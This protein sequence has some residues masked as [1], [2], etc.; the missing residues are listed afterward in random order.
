MKLGLK[1]NIGILVALCAS[2]TLGFNYNY[3]LQDQNHAPEI[4]D[5]SAAVSA[6]R[7][8]RDQLVLPLRSYSM[9]RQ[10]F[11]RPIVV[12]YRTSQPEEVQQPEDKRAGSILDPQVRVMRSAG[13]RQDLDRHIRVTRA[14][15]G[16]AGLGPQVRVMRSA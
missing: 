15:A 3:L 4:S 1:Y 2:Q 12:S 8:S 9:I 13:A 14:G 16:E 7:G 11:H 5:V 6:E 10:L